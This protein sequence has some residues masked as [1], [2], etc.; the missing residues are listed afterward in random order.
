MAQRPG[1]TAG[2]VLGVPGFH[3]GPHPLFEVGDDLVGYP[4]V[5]ILV[6]GVFLSYFGIQGPEWLGSET[7][8]L[9][10]FIVMSF[11]GVGSFMLIYLAGLQNI[12]NALYD[13]ATVDGASRWQKFM[14]VTLPSISPILLFNTI[15][16]MIGTSQVFTPA[17]GDLQ[18]AFKDLNDAVILMQER[19]EIWDENGAIEQDRALDL[20]DGSEELAAWSKTHPGIDPTKIARAF[21]SKVDL[22]SSLRDI[23]EV[24]GYNKKDIEPELDE[25]IKKA[26]DKPGSLGDSSDQAG[27]QPDLLSRIAN[28][29]SESLLEISDAEAAK[30]EAMLKQQELKGE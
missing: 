20:L 24:K 25:K 27:G 10:A 1:D 21:N 13:A 2:G 15:M 9:P 11:W 16:G 6:H 23:A 22:R 28:L 5:D 26:K 30:I 8:V 19:L 18:K 29:D 4:A 7:W 14:H 17:Y 3:P 12:P